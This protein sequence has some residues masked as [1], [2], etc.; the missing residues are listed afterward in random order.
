MLRVSALFAFTSSADTKRVPLSHWLHLWED[1][2]VAGSEVW[3]LEW[4]IK[5][6]DVFISQKL[7]HRQCVVGWRVVL[8][9]NPP[10]SPSFQ[11]FPSH[12]FTQFRQV[13]N[14]IL[15]IYRLAAGY[16][17]CQH[18]TLDIKENNQHG[19]EL[20]TKLSV[21]FEIRLCHSNTRARNTQS[22]P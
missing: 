11:S 2:E 19:I 6:S 10:V 4:V 3:Q 22:S 7:L 5:Q 17:L 15:Q 1:A 8:V 14:V 9:Q 18:S 20:R 16:P 12:T 21:P 13:F